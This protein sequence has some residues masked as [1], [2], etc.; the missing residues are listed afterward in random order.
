MPQ[1]FWAAME[2]GWSTGWEFAALTARCASGVWLSGN[3]GTTC[4]F[5]VTF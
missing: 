5:R 4:W 3:R 1:K 2:G